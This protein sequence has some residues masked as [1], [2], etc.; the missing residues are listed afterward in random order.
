[1]SGLFSSLTF[2]GFGPDALHHNGAQP[3]REYISGSKTQILRKHLRERCPKSPGVYGM[4]DRR[5]ALIYVGKA[6]SLRV[7]LMGYFR[8]ASRDDKAGRIIARARV[9]LWEPAANEFAALVRELELIRRWRPRYNVLGMPGRERHVYLCLGRK[10]APYAYATREPSGKEVACYGPIKGASF[11]REAA[12]RLNDLFRL[13]DCAQHQRM[14]FADVK[15]LFPVLRTPGCLRA[16]LGTCV[17]P[18]ASLTTKSAYSKHVRG[19]RALLDG[20]DLAP[21]QKLETEMAAAAENCEFE[22]AASL[23]DRL[24]PLQWLRQRLD[25]L[26]DARQEYSFVYPV[27][28]DAGG[29]FWYLIHRGRVCKA[30]PIPCDASTRRVAA[31]AIDSVYGS[32]RRH[33]DV[34]P[35]DQVDHVLLVAAWFRKHADERQQLLRPD[36]ALRQCSQGDNPAIAAA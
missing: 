28:D 29:G 13:R 33:F 4:L 11:V 18:C 23:R 17:G 9:I 16:D 8:A 30:V 36:D 21:M 25:W 1:V 15:E 19:A 3:D 34:V 14:H 35:I 6:K 31:E 12:R 32:G 22:K 27:L 20:N 5:G 7:R 10:P 2:A 24:L 26:Q